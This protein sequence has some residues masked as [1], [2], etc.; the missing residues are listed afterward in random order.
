MLDSLGLGAL[1]PAFASLVDLGSGAGI[2]GLPLAIAYPERRF[3]LVEARLRRSHFQQAARRALALTNV[4]L[5]RGRAERLEPSP[6]DLAVARAMASPRR[7]LP[8]LLRWVRPGGTIAIPL[9]PAAP[10]LPDSDAGLG[11][12]AGRVASGPGLLGGPPRRVWLAHRAAT[13]TPAS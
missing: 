5:L 1:L 6:Q 13:A 4:E 12:E 3:T 10:S 11:Y 2:P 8:W 9:G 7:A